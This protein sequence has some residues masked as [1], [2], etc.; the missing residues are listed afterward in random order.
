M[1]KFHPKTPKSSI[2]L[3]KALA[4]CFLFSAP[5]HRGARGIGLT[6]R[7]WF[8]TCK[9]IA[10]VKKH[11]ASRLALQ[12]SPSHVN[13]SKNAGEPVWGKQLRSLLHKPPSFAGCNLLQAAERVLWDKSC[14]PPVSG[15][16]ST[17]V[18]P[19]HPGAGEGGKRKHLK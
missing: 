16:V 14:N 11:P 5:H 19:P 6:L 13:K 8:H 9:T 18:V 4:P 1:K 2:F 10:G 12:H 17:A 3:F 15:G 7:L